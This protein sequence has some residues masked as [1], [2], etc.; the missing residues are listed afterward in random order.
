MDTLK[1]SHMLPCVF[2][3]LEKKSLHFI[4]LKGADVPGKLE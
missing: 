1:L 3:L 2:A 4:H